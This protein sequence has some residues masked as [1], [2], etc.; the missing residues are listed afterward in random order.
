MLETT[1]SR[2]L[3]SS[4]LSCLSNR[5]PGEEGFTLDPHQW[6]GDLPN[7]LVAATVACR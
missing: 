1:G 4:E 5:D 7:S 6:R 3:E 2:M